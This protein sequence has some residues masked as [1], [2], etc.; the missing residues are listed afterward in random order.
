MKNVNDDLY[1]ISKSLW[2]WYISTSI[3]FLDI[4]HRLIYLKKP[5]SFFFRHKV[6]ETG[7]CPLPQV[8]PTQLGPINIVTNIYIIEETYEKWYRVVWLNVTDVSEE[9]AASIIMVED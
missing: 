9:Y 5:S 2:R 4:I 6:S 7:F 8:K 3:M 1:I